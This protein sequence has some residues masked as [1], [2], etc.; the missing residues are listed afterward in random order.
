MEN[1]SRLSSQMGTAIII[2]AIFVH[3]FGEPAQTI[4]APSVSF[5]N[6]KNNSMCPNPQNINKYHHYLFKHDK[7]GE[8]IIQGFICTKSY[9][10][11]EFKEPTLR[12]IEKEDSCEQLPLGRIHTPIDYFQF[13]HQEC[14]PCFCF[15]REREIFYTNE[16]PLFLLWNCYKYFDASEIYTTIGVVIESVTRDHNDYNI[17]NFSTTFK[18]L[19]ER[20][21]VRRWYQGND[22]DT[23]LYCNIT[24]E[25][26][27]L[28]ERNYNHYKVILT[29]IVVL[30]VV[31]VILSANLST[32]KHHVGPENGEQ[33]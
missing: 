28:K 26:L 32:R 29:L 14:D 31:F 10:Y 19:G 22:E 16:F 9:S 1:Y 30:I 13:R 2:F 24:Y 6:W 15:G 4:Y 3:T 5:Y 27:V 18:D 20:I 7:S 12:Y 25:N 17:N 33:T 8:T 21:M 11:T 23:T